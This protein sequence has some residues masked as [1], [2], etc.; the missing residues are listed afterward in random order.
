MNLGPIDLQS[1]ALPLSYV[2]KKKLLPAGLEPAASRL[3]GMRSIIVA[4][5]KNKQNRLS[6]GSKNP[7][8]TNEWAMG[9]KKVDISRIRTY[10]GRAQWI[11]SPSP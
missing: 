8:A 6:Y 4:V 11:S 1:T 5:Q 2:P 9:A 10:A 3:L 7:I